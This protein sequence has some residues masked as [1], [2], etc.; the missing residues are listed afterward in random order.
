MDSDKEKEDICCI[1]RE[2]L[3]VCGSINVA[4]WYLVRGLLKGRGR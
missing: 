2:A 3:P 4:A 1:R